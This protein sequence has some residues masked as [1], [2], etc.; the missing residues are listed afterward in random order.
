VLLIAPLI[1]GNIAGDGGGIYNY[2]GHLS[3]T[4]GEFTGNQ[5]S[6]KGKGGE[7]YYT[8]GSFDPVGYDDLDLFEELPKGRRGGRK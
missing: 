4:D 2:G 3:I 1:A 8:S 6:R 5:V 7:I